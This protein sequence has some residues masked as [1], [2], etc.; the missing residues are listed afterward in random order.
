MCEHGHVRGVQVFVPEDLSCTGFARFKFAQVDECIAPIVQALQQAGINMRGSCCG[1][2]KDE[3]DI[4]LQDGR[5][6]LI[7]SKEVGD[8]YMKYRT[9][10]RNVQQVILGWANEQE[11][12]EDV[13]EDSGGCQEPDS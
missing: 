12:K 6:L 5:V 3:G 4:H 11:A 1:H 7:L 8:A 13:P 2:G 10:E 9:K